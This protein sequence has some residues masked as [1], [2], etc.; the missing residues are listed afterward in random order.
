MADNITTWKMY[1]IASTKN[2]K[3]GVAEK[4]VT[5]FQ[6]FFVDLDPP[7]FLTDGDEIYLPTQ[8]RNYTE[9]KQKVDVTMA[10]ADWFVF[11]R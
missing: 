1:T 3:I 9:K 8:V 11:C 7:K 5:A 6:S 4:E 10:K 2:G